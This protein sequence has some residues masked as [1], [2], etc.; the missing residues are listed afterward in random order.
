MKKP[1]IKFYRRILQI[2]VAAAFIV[3]PY[4]N[5]QLRI[6]YICGNFLSVRIFGLTLAD[7]LAVLQVSIQ[8]WYIAPEML[9]AAG[10][11]LALAIFLGTV[12]CSWICPYGLLSEWIH[13]L[14]RRILPKNYGGLKI[15]ISAFRIKICIFTAGMFFTLLF[16]AT[17]V[18][19]QFSMPAWYSRIFQYIFIQEHLSLAAGVIAAI[20]FI[21]FVSRNRL[22]CRY[23]CPQAILLVLAKLVNP[24]RLKVA[25]QKEKCLIA[26]QRQG[27]CYK[28][29]SLSLD[30][31]TFNQALETECNNCG[32][33]VAVCEKKGQALDF[34]VKR[35]RN[36]GEALRIRGK[37]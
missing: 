27:P 33:C 8:N 12:F 17:P 29:C 14:A 36:K 3:I 18:M 21:E 5:H 32:D 15:R 10:I 9:M 34:Q 35:W 26:D 31:K 24:Y 28:A 1:T 30:L 25:Y 23:L 13:W 11:V 19:N 6:N 16:A 4:L 37:Y 22:W 7:P 20:L 2:S